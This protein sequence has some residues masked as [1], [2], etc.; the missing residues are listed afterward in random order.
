[1][2]PEART[3]R[4]VFHVDAPWCAKHPEPRVLRL[5]V[6]SKLVREV[7]IPCEGPDDAGR[8]VLSFPDPGIEVEPFVVEDGRHRFTVIDP[9][10]HEEDVEF[11]TVPHV[12]VDRN[13]FE[14]GNEFEVVEMDGSLRMRGPVAIRMPRL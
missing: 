10:T 2:G 5:E 12:E 14:V 1:M 7:S 13:A 4:F 6:D 3:V 9:K 8:V 11:A